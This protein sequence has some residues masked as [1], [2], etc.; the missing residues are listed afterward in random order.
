LIFSDEMLLV[1]FSFLSSLPSVIFSVYYEVN[2][3]KEIEE[4]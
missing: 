3:E 2:D 1:V 4:K